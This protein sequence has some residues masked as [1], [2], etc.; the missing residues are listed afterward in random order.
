MPG[1]VVLVVDD[2][3][4]S[5][6]SLAA[7]LGLNRFTGMTASASQDALGHLR[8]GLRPCLIL[9]A[10]PD[11]WSVLADVRNEPPDIANLPIAVVIP[12][13]SDERRALAMGIREALFKPV[14]YPALIA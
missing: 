8:S 6:Q 5:R 3:E 10:V 4:S 14:D 7:I 11:P 9:L 2:D 1:H 13:P 12:V